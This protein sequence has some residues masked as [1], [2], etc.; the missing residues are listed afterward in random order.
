MVCVSGIGFLVVGVVGGGVRREE[1]ERSHQREEKKRRE[2]QQQNRWIQRQH[3]TRIHKCS[4]HAL[5]PDRYLEGG[6]SEVKDFKKRRANT[7]GKYIPESGEMRDVVLLSS[8]AA[9]ENNAMLRPMLRQN[10][11]TCEAH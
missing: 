6:S 10:N 1:G 5:R 9:L 4:L 7:E 3:W 8:R 2:K 11:E